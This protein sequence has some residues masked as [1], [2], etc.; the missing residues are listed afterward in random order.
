MI[1][2]VYHASYSQ[3]ALPPNHRFPVSKYQ[4]LKE[5]L[6][7]NGHASSSQFHAPSPV[8]ELML[9][10]LHSRDYVQGFFNNRL[11]TKVMRRI[12]FP[13]TE[14][15][16]ERTRHAVAGTILTAQ[17]A[18]EQSIALHLSGGYHHAHKD[19]GS[20]FCVFNDLILAARNAIDSGRASKVLIID[21][22][23][24][25]GDGTASLGQ[26]FDDIITCSFHA[27]RNFPARKQISDHDIE[28]ADGC[29]DDEYLD[30]VKDVC[31]Y[32]LRLYQPDLIL[33]DAGV[34]IH[35]DDDL[36][37]LTISTQGLA[38]RD[39]LILSLARE[40]HIPIAC[41]IGGGYSKDPNALTQRHSQLFLAANN[42]FG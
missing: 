39:S 10:Q 24:H 41:V 6:L 4:H 9:S 1:P 21:C 32:L 14:Q 15:L 33:Y 38:Q 22:D 7:A 13:W 8:N 37:Y 2:L 5:F 19:F 42:V 28:F 11:D 36:G 31:T 40:Q 23:V 26:A 16:L 27:A 20:G 18:T 35:I 25:Q 34:D 30:T 17:L 12:G 29:G 3:L